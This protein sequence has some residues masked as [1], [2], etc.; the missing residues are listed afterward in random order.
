MKSVGNIGPGGQKID[1]VDIKLRVVTT[2]DQ[3][4]Q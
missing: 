1:K 4:K 3:G 2:Q